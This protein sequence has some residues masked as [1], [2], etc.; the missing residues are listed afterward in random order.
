MSLL[1]L[2]APVLVVSQC[3]HAHIFGARE[4]TVPQSD[5]YAVSSYNDYLPSP[6][7]YSSKKDKIRA[8]TSLFQSAAATLPASPQNVNYYRF[9]VDYLLSKVGQAVVESARTSVPALNYTPSTSDHLYNQQLLPVIVVLRLPGK[10]L[11]T[12]LLAYT[13]V[14]SARALA[15]TVGFVAFANV[16]NGWFDTVRTTPWFDIAPGF[17]NTFF[18]TSPLCNNDVGSAAHVS[19]TINTARSLAEL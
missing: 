12:L 8:I 6:L 10:M 19:H 17:V 18:S 5:P 14:F 15:V 16:R 3:P 7:K 11:P 13:G 4:T 2:L 1:L 9:T